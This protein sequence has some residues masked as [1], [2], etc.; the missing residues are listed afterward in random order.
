MSVTSDFYLARV[1]QCDREAGETDL[2]NVRDR[3]LRAKAA[4]QAMADRVLKGEADRKQQ[5]AHKA[6]HQERPFG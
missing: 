5:A 1:A 6:V 4:W 2:A 3:C